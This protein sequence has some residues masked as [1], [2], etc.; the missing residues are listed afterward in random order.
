MQENLNTVLKLKHSSLS[1]YILKKINMNSHVNINLHE[2]NKDSL[3]TDLF[4]FFAINK[5]E[6]SCGY[7]YSLHTSIKCQL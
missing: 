5:H 6:F 7:K 2:S 4:N 1:L 3:D